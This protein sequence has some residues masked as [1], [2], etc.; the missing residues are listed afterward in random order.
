[1]SEAKLALPVIE[2][3]TSRRDELNE[4]VRLATEKVRNR[5]DSRRGPFVISDSDLS[6]ENSI[7]DKFLI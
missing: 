1:M 2:G 6:T 4:I 5:P 7:S 3:D